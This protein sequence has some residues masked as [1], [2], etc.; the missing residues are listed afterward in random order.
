MPSRGKH[1][2]YDLPLKGSRT[3]LDFDVTADTEQDGLV[4]FASNDFP[5]SMVAATEVELLC[6]WIDVVER[7][8]AKDSGVA[9]ALAAATFVLDHLPL[10]GSTV[11]STVASARIADQLRVSFPVVVLIDTRANRAFADEASRV[12]I[13]FSGHCVS[14]ID[15]GADGLGMAFEGRLCGVALTKSVRR[16]ASRP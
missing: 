2:P 7:K 9:A 15:N 11:Y 8:N 4:E 3:V 13:L 5:A 16:D 10:Q 14:T 6:R 12:A 1:I